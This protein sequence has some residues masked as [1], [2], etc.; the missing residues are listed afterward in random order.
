MPPAPPTATSPQAATPAV[1]SPAAVQARQP[2]RVAVPAPQ[3]V[4]TAPL[5][6]A[7]LAPPRPVVAPIPVPQPTAKPIEI[8]R[9]AVAPPT[10]RPAAQRRILI[11]DDSAVVRTK[12][13]KLLG[14]H[15]WTVTQA[16]DGQD[17]L[18]MLGSDGADLLITDLEM[19][20]MD[21][22]ELIAA[23]GSRALPILAITGHDSPPPAA[24]LGAGVRAV[25]HKPW[26]DQALLGAIEAAFDAQSTLIP[27]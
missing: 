24:S 14:S 15:G 4:P 13:A 26:D 10:P 11:V 22:R 9:P 6:A 8:A 27:N 5:P 25:L 7:D 3:R 16:R 2:P 20:Q 19:P 12:L 18:R 1:P 17:A 21:G 23:L